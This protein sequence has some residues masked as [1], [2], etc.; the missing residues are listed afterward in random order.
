[1]SSQ[2]HERFACIQ[3]QQSN[4]STPREVDRETFNTFEEA[5]KFYKQHKRDSGWPWTFWG[6]PEKVQ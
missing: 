3:Y 2:T 5:E 6:Y 4:R 1:M